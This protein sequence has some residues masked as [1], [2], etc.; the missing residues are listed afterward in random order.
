MPIDDI[1][2]DELEL[3]SDNVSRDDSYVYPWI[4]CF[5]FVPNSAN[6]DDDSTMRN[7]GYEN[8]YKFSFG[9]VYTRDFDLSECDEMKTALNKA[10]R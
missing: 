1:S 4:Y 10:D 3:I 6:E 7:D 2:E 5:G 9:T 8:S